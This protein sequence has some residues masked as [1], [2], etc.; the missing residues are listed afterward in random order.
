MKSLKNDFESLIYDFPWVSEKGIEG[1]PKFTGMKFKSV[2]NIVLFQEFIDHSTKKEITYKNC[3]F[4]NEI[5]EI[6]EP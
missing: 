4:I 6:L 1:I 5:L 3:L 2:K